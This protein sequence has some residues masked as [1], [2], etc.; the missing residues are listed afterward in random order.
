MSST[1]GAF[2][3]PRTGRQYLSGLDDGRRVVVEGRS[4]RDVAT[5]EATAG[6]AR[7]LAGLLDDAGGAGG[8][9][10]WLSR[11]YSLAATAEEVAA[12]GRAFEAVARRS[13]GLLGR[14]PDFLATIVTAWAG[15]AD[16]FGPYAGNVRAYW[17][18]SRD[19]RRVLTHAIS[20]PP[21]GRDDGLAGILRIVREDADGIVVRGTKMLATLAPFADELL[22]YPYRP[23]GEDE[24][25]RAV[26][27]AVPVAAPG[28][29]LYCR[30]SLAGGG[31]PLARRYD[32][33][34]ALC[35]FDDVRVP[36]PRV[37]IAGDLET[38]NGLRAGTEMTAYAWHQSSVRAFV[39]AEFL[40]AVADRCARASGRHGTP[41]ARSALGELAG[42]AE[43]LRSL[44]T[45]AEAGSRKGANGHRICDLT[46]LACA[47][48][49][50]SRLY[51]RAVE[52]VQTIGSSGLVMHPSPGDDAPSSEARE[53]YAEY[54]SR[55][56]VGAAE[57]GRLLRIAA[58]LALDRFG[59]R[60]ALYE[61]VFVGPPDV[62]AGKFLD[63]YGA[64]RGPD[65]AG[66]G[67]LAAGGGEP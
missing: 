38:A 54:F 66:R 31:G 65:S 41:P 1:A 59:A 14:S 23:L 22:I 30:P 52:I 63:I 19:A 35:V 3:F 2:P 51:P 46:P 53:F 56:T 62:F 60:Q 16:H 25:A 8:A 11:A 27:F 40:W 5:D 24:Q 37:F 33:M 10:D 45:A 6:M 64:A 29:T 55:E 67:P 28:L 39:K 58:D 18:E 43:T 20:D 21:A 44:V 32:E 47:A 48:M 61:R 34:D 42:I 7:E 26:C 12:R 15:A 17:A 57:H 50:N 9:G 36:W 13:G 4:V 49:L